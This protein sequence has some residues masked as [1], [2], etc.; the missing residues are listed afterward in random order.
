[1]RPVGEMSMPD[2]FRYREVMDRGR[3]RHEKLDAFTARHPRMDIGHRA[4]IFMPFDALKGFKEAI[5][6]Q[7]V[8][9]S[10]KD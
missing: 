9:D 2:G 7:E 4:K 8:L 1:M 3:P 5:T 10:Q 6:E